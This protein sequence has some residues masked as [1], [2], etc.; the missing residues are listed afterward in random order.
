MAILM[1]VSCSVSGE[2]GAPSDLATDLIPGADG[3]SNELIAYLYPIDGDESRDGWRAVEAP[4]VRDTNRSL[5]SCLSDQSLGPIGTALAESEPIAP[6]DIWRF[7]DFGR[8]NADGFNQ[9]AHSPALNVIASVEFEPIVGPSHPMVITLSLNP[10]FGIPATVDG[11][12][13]VND[14]AR[15][16]IRQNQLG[17]EEE[18]AFSLKRRWEVELDDVDRSEA[19]TLARKDAIGCLISEE[20]IPAEVESVDDVRAA[21]SGLILNLRVAD[22]DKSSELAQAGSSYAACL[23]PFADSRRALRL[24]RR[25]AVLQETFGSLLVL[26]ETLLG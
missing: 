12:N 22:G 11:A 24:E 1:A 13:L 10:E 17:A 25:Q 20:L 6:V 18:L 4:Q 19:L 23:Q 8:L 9:P 3:L 21:L 15:S 2:D 26:E 16:C 7:P 5:A 14:V